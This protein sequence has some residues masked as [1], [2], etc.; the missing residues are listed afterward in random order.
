MY[1]EVVDELE[2]VSDQLLNL[3]VIENEM[4]RMLTRGPISMADNTSD[5]LMRG[6]LETKC[7]A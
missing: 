5:F 1:L 6:C 4:W 3:Q 7:G 2:Q